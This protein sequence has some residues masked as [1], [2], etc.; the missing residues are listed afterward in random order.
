MTLDSLKE[1]KD[2]LKLDVKKLMEVTGFKF[3]KLN[4]QFIKACCD[5]DDGTL[6]FFTSSEPLKYFL[7]LNFF[8]QVI[9]IFGDFI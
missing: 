5:D 2:F 4:Y 7:V 3:S 6:L 9:S 8:L 1:N